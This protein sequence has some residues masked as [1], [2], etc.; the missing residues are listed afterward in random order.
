ML[1]IAILT[2]QW[3]CI[4]QWRWKQ[5]S[6]SALPHYCHG[7]RVSRREIGIGLSWRLEPAW[8]G[9]KFNVDIWKTVGRIFHAPLSENP[10][11]PYTLLEMY[12]LRSHHSC[13]SPSKSF[14]LTE[15]MLIQRYRGLGL[16]IR[17]KTGEDFGSGLR[18]VGGSDRKFVCRRMRM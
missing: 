11:T 1:K 6:M 15:V 18:S 2:I 8:L 5:S 10:G 16:A 9:Y 4:M 13:A 3:R 12:E 7:S 17:T 14:A